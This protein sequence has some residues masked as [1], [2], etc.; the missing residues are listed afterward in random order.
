MT[1]LI[2][3]LL[4]AILSV[5]GLLHVYW[6]LW[7]KRVSTA[8]VPEI[9]GRPAFRPSRL[10]TLAVALALFIAAAVVAFAGRLWVDPLPP[11]LGR[12]LMFAL[13]A[14]FVARAVGD[15]RL[16]GLFKRPVASRFARLDTWV[17]SPLCLL[18]GLA[19]LF[20]GYRYV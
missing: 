9:D 6:A 7:W 19:V 16:L 18:L 14:L 17:Y 10:G 4:V 3:L 20:V 8:T 11:P 2:A 15:F 12:L 13:G 1:R 5:L